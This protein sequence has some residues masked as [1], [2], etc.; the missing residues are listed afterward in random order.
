MGAIDVALRTMGYTT[1]AIARV[2][3]GCIIECEGDEKKG[4]LAVAAQVSRAVAE[5]CAGS[6]RS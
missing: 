6:K 3:A 1:D 5:H 4:G 2:T